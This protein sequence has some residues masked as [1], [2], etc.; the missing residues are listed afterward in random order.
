MSGEEREE[1][2]RRGSGGGGCGHWS[3][4]TGWVEDSYL[5]VCKSWT[6]LGWSGMAWHGRGETG[7]GVERDGRSIE[8][9]F[10]SEIVCI[11]AKRVSS[12]FRTFHHPSIHPSAFTTTL[13]SPICNAII[14]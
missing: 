13:P 3:S 2:E 9:N 14:N 6:G 7:T 12:P 10:L 11:A 1:R 5:L 8:L 4:M